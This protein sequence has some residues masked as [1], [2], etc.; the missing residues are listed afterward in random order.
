MRKDWDTYFMEK[1][2][3]AATRSTCLRRQVGAVVVKD[4]HPIAEGYNGAPKGYIHC[5]D[6]GVCL[7]D[8]NKIASGTR[9]EMCKA[10]HAEQNAIIQCAYHGVSC[11]GGTLYVTTQPCSICAKI[12]INSGIERVVWKGDY[13]DDMTIDLFKAAGVKLTKID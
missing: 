13:P 1:A 6:K 2:E 10:V 12:I 9:H 7:R 8:I 5:T 11:N 3:H 4:K